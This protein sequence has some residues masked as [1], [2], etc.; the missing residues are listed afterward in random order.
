MVSPSPPNGHDPVVRPA[1]RLVSD[2]TVEPPAPEDEADYV[3]AMI[4]GLLLGKVSP[5]AWKIFLACEFHDAELN[6]IRNHAAAVTMPID[7]QAIATL[8]ALAAQAALAQVKDPEA[9]RPWRMR[10]GLLIGLAL[11]VF[12]YW[13]AYLPG[14]AWWYNL[15]LILL[16]PA[17][18]A[19]IVGFRNAQLRTG[20]HHPTIV[21]HNRKG[22]V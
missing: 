14:M 2:R 13:Y 9:A 22:R 4:E 3:I 10:T 7:G 20:N 15:H 18:G 11:G 8:E 6:R 5:R 21:E 17:L 12:A 1:L 16:P 19:A